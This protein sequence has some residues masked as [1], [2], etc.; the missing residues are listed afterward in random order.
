MQKNSRSEFYKLND[1]LVEL[2][3]NPD[4]MNQKMQQDMNNFGMTKTVVLEKISITIKRACEIG[5]SFKA[6]HEVIK[7]NL[8]INVPVYELK[9]FAFEKGYYSAK[10]R[11]RKSVSQPK[12][13]TKKATVKSDVA[14]APKATAGNVQDNT[15]SIEDIKNNR[16]IPSLE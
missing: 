12:V 11:V 14:N 16:V 9:K 15:S 2:N 6:L 8:D 7:N 1:K 3:A 4:L 5:F 10:T 13:A